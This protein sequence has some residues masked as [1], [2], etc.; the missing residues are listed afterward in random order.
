[1]KKYDKIIELLK[2]NVNV[3]ADMVIDCDSYNGKL[4]EYVWYNNDEDFYDMFFSN[5]QEV[6][7]AVFYGDYRYCD[8]YVRF[9]AYGNLVTCCEYQR[10]A[11]L[12]DNVGE[13][14]DDW[15]ELW[16]SNDVSDLYND[17]IMELIK[18]SANNVDN[19]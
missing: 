7:R 4:S 13:I 1:M 5:K 10:D 12:V 9:N 14:L 8:D 15:Y 11:E 3:I 17:E 18:E 6:A 16:L 19:R 2:E